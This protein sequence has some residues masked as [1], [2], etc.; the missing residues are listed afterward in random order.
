[1]TLHGTASHRWEKRKAEDIALAVRG[2]VDVHNRISCAGRDD[3]RLDS[4]AEL[5][6]RALI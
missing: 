3:D 2:V 6:A 1:V 4:P 5:R